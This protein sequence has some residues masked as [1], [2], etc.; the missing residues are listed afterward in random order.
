MLF[1]PNKP[2]ISAR[3][4]VSTTWKHF[5]GCSTPHETTLRI[6][7]DMIS[8]CLTDTT[9]AVLFLLMYHSIL[10][11]RRLDVH[12][13]IVGD[14]LSGDVFVPDSHWLVFS[15]WSDVSV[16]A[17]TSVSPVPRQTLYVSCERPTGAHSVRSWLF[18]TSSNGDLDSD[19]GT[20]LATHAV[21]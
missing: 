21:I 1:I 5:P 20:G 18:F 16:G 19:R 17:D 7:F 14:S 11:G 12:S 10:C 13:Q 9:L 4:A 2:V 6:F 15:V 8:T 3:R